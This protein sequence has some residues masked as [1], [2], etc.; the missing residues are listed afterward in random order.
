M[1]PTNSKNQLKI[2][3]P[4]WKH[5][6]SKLLE[7]EI[8]KNMKWRQLQEFLKNP[9]FPERELILYSMKFKFDASWNDFKKQGLLYDKIKK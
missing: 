3:F 1:K 9:H 7:E 4:T 5:I 6:L 2:T 8:Q